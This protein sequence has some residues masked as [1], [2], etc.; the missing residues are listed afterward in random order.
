MNT[1]QRW[2][3]IYRRWG[4]TVSDSQAVKPSPALEEL[5]Q[6]LATDD[7]ATALRA[8]QILVADP[9][10]PATRDRACFGELCDQFSPDAWN[11]AGAGDRAPWVLQGLLIAAWPDDGVATEVAALLA[12]AWVGRGSI[13]RQKEDLD[14]WRERV[15]STSLRNLRE[16]KTAERPLQV[17]QDNVQNAFRQ[18]S[19]QA[20]QGASFN[21]FA[22]HL[23]VLL[24]AICD[25]MQ[26]FG[27]G[28]YL[29]V[30]VE[31][32][33]SH[34]GT[35]AG[36]E[37]W[38][39]NHYATQLIGVLDPVLKTYHDL[40]YPFLAPEM[41]H[42]T[43]NKDNPWSINKVGVQLLKILDSVICAIRDQERFARLTTPPEPL[44]L[45]AEVDLLWWGQAGYCHRLRKPFRKVEEP[46]RRLFSAV[47]AADRSAQ[48][49][50]EASAA[51]LVQTLPSLGL[52][53]SRQQTLG[54]WMET[55]LQTLSDTD[56]RGALPMDARFAQ[57]VKEDPL[58]LPV[59]FVRHLADN[60]NPLVPEGARK[61]VGLD[62]DV[63]IDQGDW[64][65][66]IYREFRLDRMF[67]ADE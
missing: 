3:Q 11:N 57:L 56:H 28:A 17:M 39:F 18:L 42:L 45:R 16:P 55:L 61:R 60:K 49:S 1:E 43:Q 38:T 6:L 5:G 15:I 25:D 7:L 63:T 29:T 58:G 33:I 59:S 53:I 51:Y 65:S 34:F 46:A 24:R 52:D 31:N 35:R 67:E 22:P 64:A 66:W 2:K 13:E 41:L 40:G 50:S 26:G 10:S 21:V 30:N 48:L 23:E 32:H 20:T 12:D 4:I 14:Q 54:D 44:S 27:G 62:L 19:P 37:K 9:E 8:C 36:T 47:E